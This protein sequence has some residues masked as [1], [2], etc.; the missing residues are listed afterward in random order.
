MCESGR[1]IRRSGD[2]FGI[3]AQRLRF[4]KLLEQ[5]A[6]LPANHHQEVVEVVRY[7]AGQAAD[8]FHFLGLTQLLFE[9]L[10]A[11]EVVELPADGRELT[12]LAEEPRRADEH[13]HGATMAAAERHLLLPHPPIARQTGDEVAPTHLAAKGSE[14]ASLNRLAHALVAEHPRERRIAIRQ[15]T[16]DSGNEVSREFGVEQLARLAD[17]AAVLDCQCRATGQILCSR[18]IRRVEFRPG[19]ARAQNH[20]AGRRG[21]RDNRHQHHRTHAQFTKG[22]HRVA[23]A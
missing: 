14:R 7:A 22:S 9:L 15:R 4:G 3:S 10:V 19:A 20:H 8:S 18:Q 13:V 5:A 16:V 2:G 6:S 1:P 11:G 23:R 17:Q 12:A 21:A